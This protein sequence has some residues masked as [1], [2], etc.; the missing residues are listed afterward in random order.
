MS[1]NTKKTGGPKPKTLSDSRK[2]YVEVFRTLP[3]T[4]R[5]L[6]GPGDDIK[7]YQKAPYRPTEWWLLNAGGRVH[8]VLRLGYLKEF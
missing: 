7:Q 2:Y 4:Q 5:L 6:V 1:K 8:R 3:D